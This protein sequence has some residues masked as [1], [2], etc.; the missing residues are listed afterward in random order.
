MKAYWQQLSDKEQRMVLIAAGSV[1]A[2]LIYLVLWI[3][4]Q[5]GIDDQA[6]R[7]DSRQSQLQTMQEQAARLGTVKRS[8]SIRNTGSLLSAIDRSA[9]QLGIKASIRKI[10]PAGTDG[11]RVW[12]DGVSFD[13]FLQWLDQLE[14]KEAIFVSDLSIDRHEQQGRVNCRLLLKTSL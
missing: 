7:L 6:K 13:S 5:Q 10:Q 1:T 8:N 9:K 12:L 3:P 4:L 2:V 14:Q 11:A